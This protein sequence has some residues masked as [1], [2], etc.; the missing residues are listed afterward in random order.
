MPDTDMIARLTD[1]PVRTD[2]DVLALVRELIGRPLTRQCWVVF[3]A[4]RG[5][6]IPLLLPVSELP[7]QPDEHVEDFAAL[8]ADVTEQVE[9][10]DVLVVW[11]RPGNDQ[12]HAVDWEWV[13]AVACSF[14]E[15]HVR[16]RGQVI[17]HDRGVEML[18]LDEPGSLVA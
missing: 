5:V 3:L 16:L 12:A 8:I 4:E 15:R 14:G 9:A 1:A 18:E 7:Y 10:D 11:E 17:V 6:P 2:A 13:D